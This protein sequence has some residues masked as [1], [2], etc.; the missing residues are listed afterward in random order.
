M[1]NGN[2]QSGK[3]RADCAIFKFYANNPTLKLH[4][5]YMHE[6]REHNNESV[7]SALVQRVGRPMS[8]INVT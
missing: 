6:N 2:E 5:G 1:L 8:A 4:I 3:P 7:H